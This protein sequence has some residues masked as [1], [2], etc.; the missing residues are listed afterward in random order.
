MVGDTVMKIGESTIERM[1]H[2]HRVLSRLID[3]KRR[4]VS[5]KQIADILTLTDSQVRKDLSCFGEIGR[6][7]IGYSVRKLYNRIDGMLE[8]D[9]V[10]KVALAGVGHL[11]RALIGH[12]DYYSDKF[13]VEA[14]FD[15]S[16]DIVG[17][18]IYGI[19]CYSDDY[20][21]EVFRAK[22]IEILILAVPDSAA[23][24]CIDAAALSGTLRGVLSFA[25][26][27]V[28]VPDGVLFYRVDFL[29]ALEK[30]FYYLK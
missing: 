5:S 14:L 8:T 22:E 30:L 12:S 27:A 18:N 19:Q 29:A 4:F 2:Y 10:W 13:A 28:T 15:V 9:K 17:T 21:A 3:E 20:I 7:G 1:V 6:R 26:S 11:G 24:S 16:P 23:Q 25:S